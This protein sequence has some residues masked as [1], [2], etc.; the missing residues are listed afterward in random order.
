MWCPVNV[1][2]ANTLSEQ[3]Q[4]NVRKDFACMCLRVYVRLCIN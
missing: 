1:V 4:E 3:A 2:Q